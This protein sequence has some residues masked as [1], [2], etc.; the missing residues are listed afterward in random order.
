MR[1]RWTVVALVVGCAT[2]LPAAPADSAESVRVHPDQDLQR[3]LDAAASGTTL[4]LMAGRHRGPITI[5]QRMTLR[6]APGARI[7]GGGRGS[8]VTVAAADVRVHTLTV[9]G[10]GH[11][12][13]ADDAGVLVLGDRAELHQ[14]RVE[15]SLHGIYLRGATS[16]R[17]RESEVVGLAAG[18]ESA[19]PPA[20]TG[21]DDGIHHNPPKARAL[22]G[23]GIH[24]WNANDAT[25]TGNHIHHVRD[26]V[27][28]AHC[29]GASFVGN[30]VHDSRYGIH[31]MYSHDSELRG[32]EL[33]RNVA[34]AA[35][36]FSRG[37]RV[38]DTRA[39]DHGG[40]RAYG[41]LLQDVDESE[42]RANQILGNRVGIRLQNSNA[43]RFDGNRIFANITGVRIG[44]ASRDNELT[45]NYIA[46]NLHPVELTGPVPPGNWSV[47][48]VGNFWDV[49]VMPLD[50]EGD[51]VS[52]WPHHEADLLAE[53]REDFPVLQMLAGSPALRMLQW[54]VRRVP[55]PGLRHIT[56][57][58]PLTTLRRDD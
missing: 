5:R 9:A 29:D 51:G 46:A 57:P 19:P 23:N 43:N 53:W 35:L 13:S 12:L 37:L 34:G 7:D 38:I 42:F 44:S 32:N 22:M 47:D 31:Y 3:A 4:E 45:R 1:G 41:I 40:L 49:A 8:V 14:L 30:R 26:G 25:I 20:A 17:V 55:V 11:D 54:A 58:D 52:E 15:R 24:L 6:G 39:R 33:W 2:F 36:M 50:L 18:E 10:S 56:D 48:G 16:V 28:V 27:Y 21:G